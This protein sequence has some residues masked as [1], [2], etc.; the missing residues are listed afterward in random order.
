[1]N[2]ESRDY[3]GGYCTYAAQSSHVPCTPWGCG[4]CDL[5]SYFVRAPAADAIAHNCSGGIPRSIGTELTLNSVR[6][7]LLFVLRPTWNMYEVLR[8]L[9]ANARHPTGSRLTSAGVSARTKRR[10]FSHGSID[11]YPGSTKY[12]YRKDLCRCSCCVC[13]GKSIIDP[14]A[15]SPGLFH[16][17]RDPSTPTKLIFL[18]EWRIHP[19][20]ATLNLSDY[21]TTRR[22][23]TSHCTL[24][25]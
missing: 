19:H 25:K 14:G 5:Y 17:P 2:S 11:A 21:S 24:P 22:A 15:R 23:V 12:K 7:G 6:R 20:S 13:P 8:S 9:K 1:M 3:L 18:S 4:W 16:L 10:C